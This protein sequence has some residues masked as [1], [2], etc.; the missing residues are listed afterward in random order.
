MMDVGEW[1]VMYYAG[2]NYKDRVMVPTYKYYVYIY[3]N[4][5]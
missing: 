5:S 1:D 2:N 3:F 4:Y